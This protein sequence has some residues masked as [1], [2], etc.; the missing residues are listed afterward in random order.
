MVFIWIRRQ[1]ANFAIRGGTLFDRRRIRVG[2][3]HFQAGVTI[4]EPR[5]LAA[6]A[7][8]FLMVGTA[9]YLIAR[10]RRERARQRDILRGRYRNHP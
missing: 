4:I 9:V 7:I 10:F 1:N 2:S 6:Y 8:I 5:T 3:R